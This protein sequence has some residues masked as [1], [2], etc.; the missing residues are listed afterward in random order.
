MAEYELYL[1]SNLAENISL[2]MINIPWLD[3][4]CK[5]EYTSK[6]FNETHS[7]IIKSISGSTSSATMTISMIK[8]YIDYSET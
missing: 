7:Y 4:N 6:N 1:S 5:I 2:E 3:V 8:Y